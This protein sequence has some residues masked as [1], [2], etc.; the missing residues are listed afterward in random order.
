MNKQFYEA[1]RKLGTPRRQLAAIRLANWLLEKEGFDYG[2]G[3]YEHVGICY[4]DPNAYEKAKE[5]INIFKNG[6]RL[7]TI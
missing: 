2:Q 7:A 3:Y 1:H 5:I 4:T 6:Q